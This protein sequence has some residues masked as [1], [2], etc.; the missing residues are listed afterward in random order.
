M[1]R[2]ETLA[3]LAMEAQVVLRDYR[4]SMA[5]MYEAAIRSG[6][7][8]A[9]SEAKHIAETLRVGERQAKRLAGIADGLITCADGLFEPGHGRAA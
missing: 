8:A 7:A 2:P 5:P 3:A 9:I 1:P 4:R 6:N